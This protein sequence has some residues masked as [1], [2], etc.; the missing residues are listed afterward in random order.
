M[1][2][3]AVAGAAVV[4]PLL[5]VVPPLVEMPPVELRPPAPEVLVVVLPPPPAA[6]APIT[7][8]P[9]AGETAPVAPW[10]PDA[11]ALAEAVFPPFAGRFPVEPKRAESP[12]A[13]VAPPDWAS[14]GSCDDTCSLHPRMHVQAIRF[15]RTTYLM[16]SQWLSSPGSVISVLC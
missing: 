11:A 16:M 9:P 1:P 5:A 8:V 3:V 2:P 13:L 12:P 6:V 7:E 15:R 4:D 10:P 14:L